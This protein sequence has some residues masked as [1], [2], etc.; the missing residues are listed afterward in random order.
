MRYVIYTTMSDLVKKIQN[1]GSLVNDRWIEK[2][3]NVKSKS[4]GM[5]VKKKKKKKTEKE[6]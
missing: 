6:T 1:R 2:E 4:K 5:T 3:K